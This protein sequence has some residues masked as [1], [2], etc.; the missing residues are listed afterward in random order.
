MP[1]H[2]DSS[3]HVPERGQGEG[4]QADVE[5]CKNQRW[6]GESGLGWGMNW[7]IL[8]K[9]KKKREG[10]SLIGMTKTSK[11]TGDRKCPN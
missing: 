8:S 3:W 1:W 5:N 2:M 11:E 7:R 9:R 6:D 4:L 10:H